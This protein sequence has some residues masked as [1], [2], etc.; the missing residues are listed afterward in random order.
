M[1]LSSIEKIGTLQRQLIQGSVIFLIFTISAIQLAK[2]RDKRLWETPQ[3]Y[4]VTGQYGPYYTL[5]D[6]KC[7]D[8]LNTN[9]VKLLKVAGLL[10]YFV[11]WNIFNVIIIL[12]LSLS[13]ERAA[14]NFWSHQKSLY[15]P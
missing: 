3:M 1:Q 2:S 11:S 14:N 4:L 7:T 13:G 10:R 6:F 12:S 5:Y 8:D 9:N 15:L